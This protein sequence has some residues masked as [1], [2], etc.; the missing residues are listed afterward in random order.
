M[1]RK[2]NPASEMNV[3]EKQSLPLAQRLSTLIT[4]VSALKDY[5]GVSAQAINQYR[6][7]ISRPSLENLCKI[8]DF[9]GVSVDYLLGRIDIPNTDLNMQEV[10]KLTG[11]SV[12]AI[13]KL[14][15]I[16]M[17]N[18]KTAFSD[19]ISLLIEDS[20]AEYFLAL[21]C[22]LISCNY[23]GS[24]NEL[25]RIDQI[26][27]VSRKEK[28]IKTKLQI[29]LIESIPAIVDGYKQQFEKSPAQR[30]KDFDTFSQS[31]IEKTL[32]GDITEQQRQKMLQVWLKE[33]ANHAIN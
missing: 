22:S 6:L 30:E 33:G 17:E 2:K 18:Q 12:G 7:G 14:N 4:D 1:S 15:N 28:L 23:D 27:M 16:S 20:N 3:A 32:S 19:I 9:Y 29:D 13:A 10:H 21:L 5:L 26:N 24:G 31:L 11:L 8:A 25:V